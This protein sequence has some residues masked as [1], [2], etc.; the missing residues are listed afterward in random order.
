MKKIPDIIN[1]LWMDVVKWESNIIDLRIWYKVY[2]F[3]LDGFRTKIKCVLKVQSKLQQ[4][5]AGTKIWCVRN[6]LDLQD[7]Q[8]EKINFLCDIE[9]PGFTLCINGLV[10]LELLS[11]R[12]KTCSDGW[13]VYYQP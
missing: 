7:M 2:Y 11:H 6:M 4:S 1:R 12:H 3:L 10:Q 9:M 5:A 13:M 8:W